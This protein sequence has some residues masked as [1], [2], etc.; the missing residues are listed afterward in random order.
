LLS[1]DRRLVVPALME[2][3]AELHQLKVQSVV[4]QDFRDPAKPRQRYHP[5]KFCDL[6]ALLLHCK[7]GKNF[8]YIYDG[9]KDVERVKTIARWQQWWSENRD[10]Y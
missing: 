2:N 4:I 7:T 8:G 9:A 3:V 10:K 6:V 1:Q 5:K